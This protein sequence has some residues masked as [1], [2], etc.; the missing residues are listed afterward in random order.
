MADVELQPGDR[1]RI[2]DWRDGNWYDATFLCFR[3]RRSGAPSVAR[4]PRERGHEAIVVQRDG[5]A[6]ERTYHPTSGDGSAVEPLAVS[7]E[8][9]SAVRLVQ[10]LVREADCAAC[11]AGEGTHR[12][13]NCAGVALVPYLERVLGRGARRATKGR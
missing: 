11:R 3:S 6:G 2:R 1:V 9:E 13:A 5:F 7:T 10:Y 12:S 8:E 4:D